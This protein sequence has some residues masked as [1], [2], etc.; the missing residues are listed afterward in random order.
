M[1]TLYFR[2]VYNLITYFLINK[3]F[4]GNFLAGILY[5]IFPYKNLQTL[6]FPD[7]YF[8]LTYFI[9]PL[10][11]YCQAVAQI[12]KFYPDTLHY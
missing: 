9:L 2:T 7:I 11:N 5:R 3:Y 1:V 4:T 6:Y 10:K 8:K 12:P